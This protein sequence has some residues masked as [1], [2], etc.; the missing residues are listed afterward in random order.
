MAHINTRGA[1]VY[2]IILAYVE[3]QGLRGLALI[4]VAKAFFIEH[5]IAED[6]ATYLA[7]YLRYRHDDIMKG[8]ETCFGKS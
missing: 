8:I 2:R 6:D 4:E 7:R 3:T 5:G 1:E